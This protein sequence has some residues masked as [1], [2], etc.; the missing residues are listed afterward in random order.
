[1]RP[2]RGALRV[3]VLLRPARPAR[4]QGFARRKRGSHAGSLGVDRAQ[5]QRVSA[6]TAQFHSALS[7]TRAIEAA[8]HLRWA[9]LLHEVGFAISHN[10]YHKHSA[11][12]IQHS[13]IAGFSTSDQERVATLVLAQR[14]NL[15]KVSTGVADR[16]SAAEHPV[17]ATGCDPRACTSRSR[18]SRMVTQVWQRQSSSDWQATGCRGIRLT[19]Y[20][21]EEEAAHWERVGLPSR[22]VPRNRPAVRTYKQIGI[23][24]SAQDRLLVAVVAR[25]AQPPYA[26]FLDRPVC[27][28]RP[29]SNSLATRPKRRLVPDNNN[30]GFRSGQSTAAA[31]TSAADAPGAISSIVRSLWCEISAS[32]S[33]VCCARTCWARRKF[34]RS[35]ASAS[36][37][38][39]QP[40]APAFRLL[41]SACGRSRV[42]PAPLLRDA[43]E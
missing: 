32:A 40:G 26:P 12:L 17:V 14:G 8:N 22:F 37:A 29:L 6:L 2:A 19:Q 23:D 30:R 43:R 18:A 24:H 31:T 36:A 1:M 39:R 28:A 42:R 33:A 4:A 38:I 9:A 27:S 34:S 5:A 11:Y 15:K 13:D 16:E 35:A 3:G 10:D 21:L 20:L 25:V 7:T 41:R